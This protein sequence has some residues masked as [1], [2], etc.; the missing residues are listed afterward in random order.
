MKIQRVRPHNLYERQC[1]KGADKVLEKTQGHGHA[2]TVGRIRQRSLA[3]ELSEGVCE[4]RSSEEE[5]QHGVWCCNESQ[6]RTERSRDFLVRNDSGHDKACHFRVNDAEYDSQNER[7]PQNVLRH[8]PSS[9]QVWTARVDVEQGPP[10]LAHSDL[11]H[12]EADALKKCV[13]H[14]HKCGQLAPAGIRK[15]HHSNRNPDD[16]VV[17]RRHVKT[18]DASRNEALV[19]RPRSHKHE[20]HDYHKDENHKL[21]PNATCN[22]HVVK[23]VHLCNDYGLE[24]KCGQHDFTSKECDAFPFFDNSSTVDEKSEN[25]GRSKLE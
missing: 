25:E 12:R 23:G 1:H 4:V 18:E 20:A 10:P 17:G 19:Q 8:S 16:E 11:N 14:Q 15:K 21:T 5:G 3:T 7:I 9:T 2:N 6:K 22:G 24:S 13:L